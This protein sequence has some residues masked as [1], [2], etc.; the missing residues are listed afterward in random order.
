MSIVMNYFIVPGNPP[1]LYFYQLW[2]QEILALAP[3][4]AVY[5]SHYA[6]LPWTRNS[7]QYLQQVAQIHIQQYLQFRAQVTGP[8][9]LVGH[10]LGG[11][12]A[13]QILQ[14][15]E[16]KVDRCIL[17]QP[18]LTRP[19]W[20]G[21]AILS[22][23]HSLHGERGIVEIIISQTRRL[24]EMFV[25]DLKHVTKDEVGSALSLAFHEKVVFGRAPIA[26]KAKLQNPKKLHFISSATDIWCPPQ[27]VRELSQW[28]KHEA[29]IASHGFVVSSHE[30]A[31][32]LKMILQII[33]E[34]TPETAPPLAIY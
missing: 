29:Q 15:L 24:I 20:K 32:M 4:S 18:F 3:Q 2:K 14:E 9:V 10:S 27:I 30:R 19:T 33:H 1:A 17:L 13:L 5:V 34:N 23:V 7:Q 16:D 11:W 28:M 22:F 21:R 26:P 6:R 12:M 31:E 25:Q 8:I